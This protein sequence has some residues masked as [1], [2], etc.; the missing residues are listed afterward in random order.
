MLKNIVI[1]LAALLAVLLGVW[2]QQVSKVDFTS[3]DGQAHRWSH[4]QGKWKVVNYF[5]EWCAPC[6]REMPE[7][8][9]FY[10]QYKDEIDIYAVSFDPLSKEKLMGLQQ[11]Y[12]IQ[13]PVIER[14]NTLPWQQ[15]PKSLPTT[16][17]LDAD[18]KVQKQ[19]KGE[20]SAQT[21]IDTI[22]TL[23]GL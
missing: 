13:F 21:L 20:Q 5:A 18:G 3:L 10:Q 17:I 7:L 12:A 8:N 15:P 23:K 19:L 4:S 14:L 9:H 6:L 2:A 16:Y 1:I 11:K 22:N